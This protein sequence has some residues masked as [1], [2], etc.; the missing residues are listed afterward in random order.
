VQLSPQADIAAVE[1]A[2]GMELGPYFP[3]YAWLLCSNRKTAASIARMP[4]VVWV[5]PRPFSHKL[6]PALDVVMQVAHPAP[7]P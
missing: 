5:G 6:A 2:V 4:G 1:E 7:R 3:N